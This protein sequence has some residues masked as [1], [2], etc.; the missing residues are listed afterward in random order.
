[1]VLSSF[2]VNY[3]SV[4]DSQ[5]F[6]IIVLFVITWRCKNSHCLVSLESGNAACTVLRKKIARRNRTTIYCISITM[7]QLSLS[8]HQVESVINVEFI[9][10]AISVH[11]ACIVPDN[12]A[13]WPCQNGS[14]CYNSAMSYSCTC[15]SG[16]TGTNCDQGL[17]L[18]ITL[19]LA[20]TQKLL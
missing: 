4:W 18:C 15:A 8:R 19:Y 1:M 16:Y 9:S 5:P 6:K 13:S 17:C 12:C 14:T 7:F 3:N 20:S 10:S 2:L 11:Y